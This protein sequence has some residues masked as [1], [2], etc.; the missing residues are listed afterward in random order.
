VSQVPQPYSFIHYFIH[1]V[2]RL[3]IVICK[4]IYKQLF[5]CEFSLL[6]FALSKIIPLHLVGL[7]A[8]LKPLFLTKFCLTMPYRFC[9]VPTIYFKFQKYLVRL[10]L[11]DFMMIRSKPIASMLCRLDKRIVLLV[12][13]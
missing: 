12:I 4:I 5:L 11:Y 13:F 2:I 7:C 8:P 9:T 6:A 10:V 1:I 3:F